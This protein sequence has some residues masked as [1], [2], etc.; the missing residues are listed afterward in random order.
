MKSSCLIVKYWYKR[1]LQK[2][3]ILRKTYTQK[4]RER[5]VKYILYVKNAWTLF[6]ISH[7]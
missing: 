3:Y 7:L 6:I 5:D 2:D 4:K 1:I